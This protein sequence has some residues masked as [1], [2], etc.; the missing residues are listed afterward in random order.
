MFED[1]ER[2]YMEQKSRMVW[3]VFMLVALVAMLLLVISYSKEIAPVVTP[4]ITNAAPAEETNS[5][6]TNSTKV[7]GVVATG[8]NGMVE[9]EYSARPTIK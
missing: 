2:R 4:V 8:S 5:V 3:S 1:D 9:V 7:D 6:A